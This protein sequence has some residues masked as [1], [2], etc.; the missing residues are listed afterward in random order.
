MSWCLLLLYVRHISYFCVMSCHVLMSLASLCT[1]Y[2]LFL[3]D[4]MSCP[5]VSCFFMYVIFLISVW[6]HVMSWCLLLLYVRHISY[7]CVMSCHV[8]MSLASLCTSYFLFLCHVM[9][10]PNVSCFFMYVI[11]LISVSCHVMSC[12]VM[13][14]SDVSCFLI[15]EIKWSRWRMEIMKL[16]VM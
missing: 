2:F 11:F 12:H 13:S 7:F 15:I 4:V 1:S 16:L 8:L 6:C 14:C 10:C 5:D 9:S 3:C